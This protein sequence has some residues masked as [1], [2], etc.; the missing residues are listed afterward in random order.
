MSAELFCGF[1]YDK[2]RKQFQ[3]SREA[4][5]DIHDDVVKHSQA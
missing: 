1:N 4:K 2:S 3:W 5:N